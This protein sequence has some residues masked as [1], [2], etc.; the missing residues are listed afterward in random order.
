[1]SWQE[2]IR[3]WRKNPP[4][5]ESVRRVLT[6]LDN[7]FENRKDKMQGSHIV[8]EDSRLKF[9]KRNLRPEDRNISYDGSFHIPTIKGRRV[10]GYNIDKILHLIDIIEAYERTRQ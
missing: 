9:Y 5:E 6:V 8:V 3:E 10:K 7:V 2:I 4:R 1:M